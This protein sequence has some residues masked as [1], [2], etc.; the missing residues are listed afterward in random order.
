MRF[1][2]S[3]S[4]GQILATGELFIQEDESGELRLSF[5]TDRGR[6]IEGGLVDADGSLANA[7]KDLFRQFFLTWG[8]S[9]ITLT[10][11]SS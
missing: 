2:I 7:S 5:R 3:G 8:V 6:I 10:A 4:S 1:A 9:G 11:R